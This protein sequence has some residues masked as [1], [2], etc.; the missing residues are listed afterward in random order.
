MARSRGDTVAPLGIV[1]S[2]IDVLDRIVA[3]LQAFRT[4]DAALTLTEI[5]NRTGLYKSTVLRL[6][7][8]LVSHHLLSKTEDGRYQLG[9]L[10]YSLGQR[11]QSNLDISD[12]L[13]PLMRSLN[14][15]LGETVAFHIRDGD[16]RV[17]LLRINSRFS[18]HAEVKLG[19]IQQLDR[20]AGGRILMAFGHA[21]GDL[22][23][24]IRDDFSYLSIGERDAETAGISSPVLGPDQKLIGAIGIVTPVTRMTSDQIG[25]FASA[26]LDTAARATAQ[27]GGDN[28]GILAALDRR[29]EDKQE[30]R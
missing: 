6:N 11:Y 9:V 10:T 20:G 19:D 26:V 2:G 1:P 7:A 29:R 22:Y 16:V 15:Q 21:E 14:E 25:P 24:G 3:I 12:V 28:S 30:R 5:S 8:S 23:D 13:L 18:V 27:L 17:C 4:G